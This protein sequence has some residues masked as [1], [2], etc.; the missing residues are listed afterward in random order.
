MAESGVPGFDLAAWNALVAPRGT[1]REIV[2][3]LNAHVVA[4]L[5]EADTRKRLIDL[6]VQPVS[7]TPKQL[8]AFIQSETQKWGDLARKAKITAD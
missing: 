1:P 5:G 8:G 6:G 3:L 7:G 2:S 4:I